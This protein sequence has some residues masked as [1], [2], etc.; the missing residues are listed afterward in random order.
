[1]KE[2]KRERKEKIFIKQLLSAKN[3]AEHFMYKNPFHQSTE[4]TKRATKM[5]QRPMLS[6][7]KI[8]KIRL[9]Y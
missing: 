8:K 4:F 6:Y 5:I 9:T 7:R 3:S 2:K 1:M